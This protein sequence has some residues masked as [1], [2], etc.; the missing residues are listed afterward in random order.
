MAYQN[1]PI[2]PASITNAAVLINN[3]TGTAKVTLRTG[4]TNGDKIESISV[5]STDTVA[6]VLNIFMNV[7]ATD[8][9]IGTINI[10]IA[11]GTDAAA[12]AS[13]SV[14]ETNLMMPWV[15]KDSNGRAYLYLAA[16]N[17]LKFASQVTV[18]AA[19]EIDI[20][21]QIGVF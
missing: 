4:S 3:A 14:L 18:T 16:S 11:A 21:A 19:K 15:R 10:P 17:I 20:V 5:T 8:Y 6:R 1:V 12:T 7:A 2:Y 13:V 9:W